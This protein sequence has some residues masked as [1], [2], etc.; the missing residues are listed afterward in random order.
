MKTA[1]SHGSLL[2]DRR[3]SLGMTQAEVGRAVGVEQQTIS[4]YESGA[5]VPLTKW[6]VLSRALRFDTATQARFVELHTAA[7]ISQAAAA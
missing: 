6:G 7:A 5:L 3:K 2:R 1:P 4:R